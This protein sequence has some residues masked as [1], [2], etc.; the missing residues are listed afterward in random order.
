MCVDRWKQ[1][2]KTDYGACQGRE[3][4]NSR[5]EGVGGN[6]DPTSLCGSPACIISNNFSIL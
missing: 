1:E 6:D 5:G 4:G 2:K 3:R